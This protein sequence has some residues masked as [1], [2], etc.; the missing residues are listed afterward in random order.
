M[1]FCTPDEYRRFLHQCPVFERMLV[2][3]GTRLI[4]YWFSVSDEEQERRFASRMKDPMRRWKLSP[5]DLESRTPVGRVLAGQR[6][7]VRPHRHPRSTLVHGGGRRQETGPAQ[8]HLAPARPDPVH[9]RGH[10][11]TRAAIAPHGGDYQRP[12]RD[13]YRAVPD[14]AEKL[15]ANT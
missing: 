9:R 8:L 13:L 14:V 3:D 11:P 7:D 5:M 2:E 1:G 6:R 10:G 15:I 4:K 12:P